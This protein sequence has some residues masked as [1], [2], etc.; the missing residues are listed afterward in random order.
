MA[1]ATLAYDPLATAGTW[2]RNRAKFFI[3][4][5][6]GLFAAYYLL[7]L[8]G[9]GRQLLPRPAGDLARTA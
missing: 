5:I 7:P 6:L 2:R 9:G 1:E 4:G 8:C 3:Y